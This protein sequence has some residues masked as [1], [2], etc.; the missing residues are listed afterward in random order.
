MNKWIAASAVVTLAASGAAI[1]QVA[2]SPVIYLDCSVNQGGEQVEWKITLNEAEG[3]VDYDNV[4]SG[5]QRRP[6][7]FTAD[8]VYFIGFTLSR[9]DLSI[10]RKSYGEWHIGTCRVAEAKARAF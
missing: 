2:A 7:R 1:A 10:K 5:P 8:A 3:I 9:T 4:I 6:A